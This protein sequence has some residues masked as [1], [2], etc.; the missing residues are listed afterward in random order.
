[1]NI[2][3]FESSEE[4][5]NKRLWQMKLTKSTLTLHLTR[6]SFGRWSL[7][8]ATSFIDIFL[9][10]LKKYVKYKVSID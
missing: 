4:N 5:E 2:V 1:M 8:W 6:K 3:A 7:N 9:K 10:A